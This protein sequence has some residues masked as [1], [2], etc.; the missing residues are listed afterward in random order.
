M[1][2]GRPK[3]TLVVPRDVGMQAA[4]SFTLASSVPGCTIERGRLELV[5]FLRLAASDVILIFLCWEFI[6]W[7]ACCAASIQWHVSL[8]K[9]MQ[10]A[11]WL[12]LNLRTSGSQFNN[13]HPLFGTTPQRHAIRDT[14][15][16]YFLF[17]CFVQLC[18]TDSQGIW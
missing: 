5:W 12:T 13:R 6:P 4:P 16:E 14:F 3:P 7:D 10:T 11:A 17:E 18:S 1:I 15:R 9:D 2:G 8:P